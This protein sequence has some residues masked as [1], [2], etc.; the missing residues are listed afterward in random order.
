MFEIEFPL[1][2]R[3]SSHD[4]PGHML[5]YR[6]C[7]THL[8]IMGLQ[9]VKVCHFVL[10]SFLFSS[11][12]AFAILLMDTCYLVSIYDSILLLYSSSFSSPLMDSSSDPKFDI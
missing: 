6:L 11:L 7:C 3:F 12:L 2:H 9:T 8:Q 4:M 5:L 1:R 10:V